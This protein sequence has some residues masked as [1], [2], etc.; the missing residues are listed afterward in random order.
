M[1]PL[2]VAATTGLRTASLF[3]GAQLLIGSGTIQ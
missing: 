2:D 1:L 3:S